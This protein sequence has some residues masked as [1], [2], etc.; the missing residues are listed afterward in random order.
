MPTR[1][2]QTRPAKQP[3][4]RQVTPLPT[5]KPDR[6]ADVDVR[7]FSTA[8]TMTR[9]QL[10]VMGALAESRGD[11]AASSQWKALVMEDVAREFESETIRE[12]TTGKP[13]VKQA[14]APPVPA[15]ARAT[16]FDR[17]QPGSRLVD[18][19]QRPPEPATGDGREFINQGTRRSPD[20][21][22]RAQAKR[23]A[24]LAAAQ[25][26]SMRG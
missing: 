23:N 26:R 16:T 15:S 1:Y 11:F 17:R 4:T 7:N 5:H 12:F 22:V 9:K 18:E 2:R 8:S 25:E 6:F 20:A 3:A 24:V 21:A 10:D 19:P 14:P 13:L